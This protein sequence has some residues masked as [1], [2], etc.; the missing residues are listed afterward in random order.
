MMLFNKQKKK[1][2]IKAKQQESFV[3]YKLE[4]SL[5]ANVALFKN[6][7][8]DDDTLIVRYFENQYHTT[9]KCCILFIC[10][11]TNNEMVNENIIQPTD[12]ISI[13]YY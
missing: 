11:M 7:F 6:I 9:I 13:W 8:K 10:G 4:N 12:K 1:V 5:D 3:G 2:D